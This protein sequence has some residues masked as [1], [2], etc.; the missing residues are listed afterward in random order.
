MQNNWGFFFFVNKNLIINCFYTKI[1]IEQ[2][3]ITNYFKY[4]HWALFK[5]KS[6]DAYFLPNWIISPLEISW[7]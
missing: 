7:I 5:Y 2:L 4:S 3:I 6:G 1:K